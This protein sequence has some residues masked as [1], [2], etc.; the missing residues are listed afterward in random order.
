MHI[1]LLTERLWAWKIEL[2]IITVA[3]IHA[4]EPTGA[5]TAPHQ[6]NLKSQNRTAPAPKNLEF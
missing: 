2:K 6:K 1:I 4:P 3:G 5:R